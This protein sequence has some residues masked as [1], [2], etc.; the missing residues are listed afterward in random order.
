MGGVKKKRLWV[1]NEKILYNSLPNRKLWRLG[2]GL[3]I[4][5]P[6]RT[7]GT[8]GGEFSSGRPGFG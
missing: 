8:G 7:F 2:F 3:R 6:G 4:F 5:F 1:N